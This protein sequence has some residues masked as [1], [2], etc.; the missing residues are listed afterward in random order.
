MFLLRWLT[1]PLRWFVR[2]VVLLV[3]GLAIYYCVT[4]IQ[5]W[6]TSRDYDPVTA[7]AIVVMG[8]AQYDGVPSPDLAAR[9]D[10]AL[11]LYQQGYARLIVCTGYKEKGDVY[12]EAE[13]GARYLE[14]KGVPAADILEAGGNDSW[15]NLVDAA[16]EL[17][18]RGDTDVL[19]V[20]DTFHEDRSMA[21][22]SSLGLTPH[23]TPTQSSPIT[24][25][26]AIPYFLKEA[27][28]VA[29][30]RVIGFQNLHALG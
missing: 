8:S 23:P 25:T 12:T 3:V 4:L 28:G 22:A 15:S 27:A 13:S 7:Q 6:L 10:Q 9:L 2:L 1:A 5:V 30:G 24:G 26:S 18:A 11:I 17:K 21:I 16:R 14:S 19:I 29:V 20:T